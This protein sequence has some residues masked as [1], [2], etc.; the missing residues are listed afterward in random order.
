M[1]SKFHSQD[2]TYLHE[3][4]A[5]NRKRKLSNHLGEGYSRK[6]KEDRAYHDTGIDEYEDYE[7]E[8]ILRKTLGL[9][10]RHHSSL[11]GLTEPFSFPRY[12]M[13]TGSAQRNVQAG[14]V[15]IRCVYSNTIFTINE[16]QGTVGYD[17]EISRVDAIEQT[18]EPH[19]FELVTLYFRIVHPSFPIL[20]KG[21][22]LEK[23]A[24]SHRE[25]S[26]ALLASVYLLA[27]Q[28][29]SFS[30]VLSDTKRPDLT[31]LWHLA[32]ESFDYT[33][34]R[35]KLSSVQAGL[36]LAQYESSDG[37]VVSS[38]SRGK[39]TAHLI[40]I[41]H[42]LGLH[43]DPTDW[44]IP[45]WEIGL[46]RRLAW[47]VYMQDKWVALIEGRPALISDLNWTV[48]MCIEQDF[49]EAQEHDE[50]GSS[51]VQKGRTVFMEMATLTTILSD[52]LDSVF[53]LRADNDI[54]KDAN[55]LGSLLQK[56]KPLQTRLRDWFSSLSQTLRMENRIATKLSST[57]KAV[58]FS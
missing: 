7:G 20:H 36:L 18:V 39:V 2:C 58:L 31:L 34:F 51:E 15:T 21:A 19:G 33:I 14:Q 17:S 57:G 56:V 49:P 26:P 46:R 3:P 37:G 47:A 32:L 22:F 5:R 6:D 28:Y 4:I 52:V 13:A 44:D 12:S 8:T 24:R 50:E 11:V 23:Y 41:A 29:W 45:L 42:R 38:G 27:S 35:P 25:F 16:D 10:N 30:S 53:S 9:M 54:T 48:N 40:S 55:P 43:L 1:L